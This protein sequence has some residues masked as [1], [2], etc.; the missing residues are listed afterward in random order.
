MLVDV[1]WSGDGVKLFENNSVI[2][3]EVIEGVI[4]E[5]LG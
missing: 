4:E 5:A 1:M 2:Q 3:G